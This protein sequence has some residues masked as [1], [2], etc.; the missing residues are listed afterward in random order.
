VWPYPGA[1]K[2]LDVRPLP[3]EK[4]TGRRQ[5]P[6]LAHATGVPFL[7]FKKPQSPF[8]SR[9]LRNKLE[10][11]HR[12]FQSIKQLDGDQLKLAAWEDGWDEC[13]RQ[14]LE[15][16]GGDSEAWAKREASE[17]SG[18]WTN[19]VADAREDVWGRIVQ[20]T[21]NAKAKA[22]KMMEIVN[23]EKELRRQEIEIQNQERR[24]RYA[25]LLEK[26]KKEE[27]DKGLHPPNIGDL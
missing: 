3:R 15:R 13:V 16:D 11:K 5:I 9:V 22:Q 20:W 8:L 18:A 17:E 1:P 7:R 25:K 26:K 24:A 4:L 27:A 6:I 14:Q 19:E 12:L 10:Q 2:V 21:V 23:K